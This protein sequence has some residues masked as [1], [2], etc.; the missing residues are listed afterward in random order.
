MGRQRDALGELPEFLSALPREIRT[1]RQPDL[2][3]RLYDR[4][5]PPAMEEH[6]PRGRDRT[7]DSNDHD[8]QHES[9]APIYEELRP[10]RRILPEV[11]RNY[12]HQR[13]SE[14]DR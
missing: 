7:C 8:E 11:R 6:P 14:D 2:P 5:R 4:H 12:W 3:G 1:G 10:G 13:I 9:E